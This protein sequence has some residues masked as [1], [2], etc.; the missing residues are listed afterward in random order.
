MD[1]LRLNTMKQRRGLNRLFLD[2]GV[3]LWPRLTN[4]MWTN[5]SPENLYL[6]VYKVLH[7]N[8]SILIDQNIFSLTFHTQSHSALLGISL[9]WL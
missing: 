2:N 4:Y 9:K 5:L 8:L 6:S 1:L 3:M 7:S